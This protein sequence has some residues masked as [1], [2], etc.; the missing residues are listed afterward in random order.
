MAVPERFTSRA[1]ALGWL[2]GERASLVAPA[3]AAATGRDQAAARLPLALAEYLPSRRRFGD[4]L[5][6]TT[7]SLSAARRLGDRRRE[8]ATLGYLGSALAEVRRFDEAIAACRHLPPDRRP[9]RR[10][11]A[12]EVGQRHAGSGAIEGGINA[13]V[14]RAKQSRM[15]WTTDGAASIIALRCQHAS[16]RWD[17]LWPATT[18]PTRLRA[19]I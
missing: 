11:S 4:L 5:A 1:A 9:P 18:P 14:H 6:V 7:V 8:G 19:A 17:E 3:M 2:D 16:G 13:V 12:A 10:E 15:H